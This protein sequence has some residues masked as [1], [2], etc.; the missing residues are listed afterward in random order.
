MA[1]AGCWEKPKKLGLGSAQ[2]TSPNMGMQV[3]T[4]NGVVLEQRSELQARLQAKPGPAA[5][6]QATTH[7]F[8]QIETT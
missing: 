2:A 5:Q 8:G 7:H 1:V 6:H 3:E 4:P